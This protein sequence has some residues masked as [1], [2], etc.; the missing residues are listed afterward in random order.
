MLK[1]T[2]TLVFALSMVMG[3]T[4]ATLTTEQQ[5]DLEVVCKFGGP[6]NYN[7]D[8]ACSEI[9]RQQG[10]AGGSC[11]KEKQL[12]ICESKQQQAKAKSGAEVKHDSDDEKN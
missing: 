1:K 10:N 8:T 3:A 6:G 2:L 11:N 5:T 12:C 4:T 7:S 9:C